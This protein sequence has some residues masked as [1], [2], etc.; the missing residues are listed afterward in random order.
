M[1]SLR[2]AAIRSAEFTD[3]GAGRLA[4]VLVGEIRIPSGQVELMLG[5]I[6]QRAAS[7]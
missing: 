6:K 4:V 5:Q 7:R 3:T 1:P 2:Y